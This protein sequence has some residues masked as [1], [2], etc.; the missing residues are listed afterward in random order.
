[1]I[2]QLPWLEVRRRIS[3]E[4]QER[5]RWRTRITCQ[6][7]SIRV[8]YGQETLPSSSEIASGGVVKTQDLQTRFPNTPTTPNFLY[9]ISSALPSYAPRMAHLASSAGAYVVLNQN[10]VAYPGW[11]TGNWETTNRYMREV[12]QQADYVFY[13]SH[14]CK[15]GADR[16]LGK[17]DQNYEILYN[18]VDTTRFSPGV[19]RANSD[20]W[21]LLLAGSHHH[22]YRVQ[23]AVDTTA[24][25]R[26][27]G[28][29]VRL[30]IAGRHCWTADSRSAGIQL[31]KYIRDKCV[32]EN[33]RLSG[34]Y[35]QNEALALLQRSDILLHTKYNDPCPRLVVEAMAAGLP[36]VYS[37][38]GGTPELVGDSAGIGVEAPLDWEKDHPPAPSDLA[39]AVER[40]V[41]Q[42]RAFS[43]EARR[44]AV[45]QFDRNP[46][47]DRHEQVFRKLLS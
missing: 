44:R 8:F 5:M 16:F 33:V 10:G 46:W 28:M 3:V 34:A 39:A 1:M 42:H 4:W 43:R 30:E 20:P 31:Q 2:T 18:P 41:S 9:L 22:F 35:S 32:E 37:A 26:D 7:D 25:L 21:R 45:E 29:N 47:I 12:L 19:P 36:V 14:F 23:T 38:S 17:R 24:L 27:A 11:Q 15:L 40:I 13:Q 6:R